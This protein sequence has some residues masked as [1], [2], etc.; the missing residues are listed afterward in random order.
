[1]PGPG[2]CLLPGGCLVP[3]G[4]CSKGGA[5]SRGVPGGLGGCLVDTPLDGYCCGRYASYCNA[6][7]LRVKLLG[8][9]FLN[10]F[11][12]VAGTDPGFPLGGA[13]TLRGIRF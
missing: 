12:L 10:I 6:F 4:V 5:W 7:L 2:G 3:G 11:K 9:I 8:R 1:M 13:S